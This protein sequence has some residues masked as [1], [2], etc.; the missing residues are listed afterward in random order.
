MAQGK[1]ASGN[2]KNRWVA[3]VTTDSTRPEP[4]LSR[5]A[6]ARLRAPW[7]LKGL[8][9]RPWLGNADVELFYKSRRARSEQG[10]PN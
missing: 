4:G 10:A 5:K 6:P 8:T 7:R 2:K 9:E 1:K 3:T